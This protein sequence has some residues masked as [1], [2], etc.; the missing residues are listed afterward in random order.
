MS[1]SAAIGQ[2]DELSEGV[3]TLRAS[4]ESRMAALRTDESGGGLDSGSGDRAAAE[5][6]AECHCQVEETDE[7][8]RNG[9]GG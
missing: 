2:G 9:Q 7:L 5:R 8:N 1:E 6:N 4:K 3:G